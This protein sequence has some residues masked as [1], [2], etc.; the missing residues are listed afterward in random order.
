VIAYVTHNIVV[1]WNR[2][3]LAPATRQVLRPLSEARILRWYFINNP[4]AVAMRSNY[5]NYNVVALSE[6]KGIIVEAGHFLT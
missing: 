6:G 1:F 4:P 3:G 5:N 2:R